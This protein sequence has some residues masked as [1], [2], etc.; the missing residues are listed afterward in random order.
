MSKI[1]PNARFLVCLE[2]FVDNLASSLENRIGAKAIKVS[3][4]QCLM[5]YRIDGIDMSLRL[6][7]VVIP[8]RNGDLLGRLS[9]LDQRGDDHICCY[10]NKAFHC[11][12]VESNEGCFK[13]GESVEQLCF[14]EFEFLTK[15]KWEPVSSHFK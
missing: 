15:T 6:R 14:Q 13:E 7:L 9:W 12:V 10:I 3:A 4:P 5:C 11:V 8:F 2:S 1:K